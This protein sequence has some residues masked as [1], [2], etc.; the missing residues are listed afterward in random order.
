[1]F[2]FLKWYFE[3]CLTLSIFL[4]SLV[5]SFVFNFSTPSLSEIKIKEEKPVSK[6]KYDIDPK[7]KFTSCFLGPVEIQR[8]Q[9]LSLSYCKREINTQEYSCPYGFIEFSDFSQIEY[10][11]GH[12]SSKGTP[13]C[14]FQK[15]C[16][17][18]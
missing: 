5:F 6:I 2:Y 16:C 15:T 4:S 10:K 17:N 18:T 3:F 11:I 14:T 12:L 9:K 8:N 7:P 1:M 13:V